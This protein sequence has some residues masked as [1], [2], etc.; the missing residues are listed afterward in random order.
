MPVISPELTD[1]IQQSTFQVQEGTYVYLK[2]QTLP[3]SGGHFLVTQDADEVTIVT[4]EENMGQCA[5]SERNRDDY[6]LI[7]LN[8][9]VPF[10][11][12]GFLAAVSDAIAR[13]GMNILVVSTYSKDYIL[14]KKDCA[15]AAEKILLELGFSAAVP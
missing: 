3:S 4:R 7:A 14:V 6:A 2:A 1:I 11:C 9:S 12:V 5:W 10:Y 8:V 15:L 13:A